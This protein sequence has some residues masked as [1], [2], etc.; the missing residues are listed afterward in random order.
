MMKLR[1]NLLF[2]ALTALLVWPALAQQRPPSVVRYTEARAYKL[3]RTIQLPG[4]VASRT[5]SVVASEIGG[6]VEELQGREGRSVKKGQPLAQLRRTNT[7]L[8]LKATEGQ[9][10][11]AEARLKLAEKNLERARELLEAQVISRQQHDDA[12]FEFNAWQGRLDQLRADRDRLQDDL[13]RSTIRAP[14]DG[15]V[16]REFTEVGQW[17]GVGDEVV[18]ILSLKEL[19]VVVDAPERYFPLLKRGT[20]TR[21]TFAALPGVEV[22]GRITA[23]IPRANAQARTFPL[24]IRIPNRGR[25]IGAGMLAQ[26]AFL[27]GENYQATIVPKDAI[28]TQGQQQLIY[29]LNGDNTVMSLPVQ[30]GEGAGAWIAV[31]GSLR[32]GQKVITRGNESLQSGQTVQA[33]RLEYTLP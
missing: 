7:A 6:L 14:F 21:V 31:K 9:L 13:E 20:R 17:V 10:R 23:V 1:C 19:E 15:I 24:K 26:V 22:L 27:A 25:R 12:F 16:V 2:L 32:P 11:E 33:E 8:R 4:T 3:R 18:E 30:T 28:I 29:L 5:T